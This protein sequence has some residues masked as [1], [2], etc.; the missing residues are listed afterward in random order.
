MVHHIKT[1]Q[2]QFYGM[3]LRLN[4]KPLFIQPCMNE[5]IT[6]MARESCQKYRDTMLLGPIIEMG[7]SLG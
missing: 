6:Q 7:G 3:A 1:N 4:Q 5:I 2:K